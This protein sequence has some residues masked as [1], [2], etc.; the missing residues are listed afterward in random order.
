MNK[1]HKIYLCLTFLI[2]LFSVSNSSAAVRR[3]LGPNVTLSWAS[4]YLAIESGQVTVQDNSTWTYATAVGW[5]FDYMT[6]PYISLRTNWFF[7]PTSLSGRLNEFK[8]ADGQ[9]MTHEIGVS[10]LRHFNSSPLNPWFGVGPFLQFATIDDVNSYT[11]HAIISVG[12]DY[13][14]TDDVY[15]CPELMWG[16]GSRIIS[17]SEDEDV[18][19]DVPTGKDF[20]SSGIVVFFKLGIGKA[21]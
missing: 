17:R 6:T 15:F 12:F 13:E 10:V 2:I 18:Q 4:S 20:S 11:I 9:I 14:M 19:I 1:I 3:M 8:E 5:F 21:F 16:I 7:Y